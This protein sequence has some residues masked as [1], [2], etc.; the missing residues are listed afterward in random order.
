MIFIFKY[1]LNIFSVLCLLNYSP[2]RHT[3]MSAADRCYNHN[4]T[5]TTLRKGTT[6]NPPVK[7]QV[8]APGAHT[9]TLCGQEICIPDSPKCRTMF[10]PDIGFVCLDCS[11]PKPREELTPPRR[12]YVRVWWGPFGLFTDV[13][14]RHTLTRYQTCNGLGCEHR[15]AEPKGY[16][17]HACALYPKDRGVSSPH[18]G[19]TSQESFSARRGH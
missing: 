7:E 3:I 5:S 14:P 8:L 11:K 6:P 19:T 18:S 10:N 13:V 17:S 4:P 16:C 2:S 9:C 12:N 1:Y 15:I